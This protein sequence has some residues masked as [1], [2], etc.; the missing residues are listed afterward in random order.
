MSPDNNSPWSQPDLAALAADPN[1]PLETLRDLAVQYPQ[2]Q[3]TIALNPS[4][5]PDLLTWLKQVGDDGVQAA[6]QHRD[7]YGPVYPQVNVPG[8]GWNQ[9][10]EATAAASVVPTPEPAA[11][12]PT[13]AATVVPTPE[14]AAQPSASPASE[15]PPV[16]A[17]DTEPPT[18]S[19][20]EPPAEYA[21]VPLP[22]VVP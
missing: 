20:T 19:A 7:Y 2:L 1:T 21:P 15:E 6:L 18:S 3:A 10:A 11:E 8:D 17:S 14:P 4:T 12:P 13:P 22:T 9:P 5:Y 16:S